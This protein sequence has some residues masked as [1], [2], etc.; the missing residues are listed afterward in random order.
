MFTKNLKAK[1][2]LNSRSPIM[3][4]YETF[5]QEK[6]SS[7]LKVKFKWFKSY[8]IHRELHKHLNVH[9]KFDLKG[10]VFKCI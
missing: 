10:Q 6:H 1:F 3:N 2:I 5:S 9:D 4:L 7:I 8:H